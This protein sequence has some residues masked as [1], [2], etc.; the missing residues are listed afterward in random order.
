MTLRISPWFIVAFIFLILFVQVVATYWHLYFYIWWFDIPMHISGGAWVALFGLASYYASLRITETTREHSAVFVI[1]FAVALTLTIGLMW[2]IYEFGVD[3][4]VG[5]SG[6]GLADT[7]KDLTDDLIGA[8][9]AAW[10]FIRFGY[11]GKA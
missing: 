4:A 8:L 10:V 11:N 5:D 6:I 7:L 9:L 3:H 2:E 1:A